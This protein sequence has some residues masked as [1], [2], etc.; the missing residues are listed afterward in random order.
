MGIF[1]GY[2]SK[3]NL[4]HWLVIG[5][6]NNILLPSE[7]KGGGFSVSKVDTF[8]RNIEKCGLIDL[9]SFGTK[10]TCQ[11][12]CRGGRIVHRRLDRGFYN[13]DWCIKFPEATMEHLVKGTK[14]TIRFF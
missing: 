8:A 3:D 5:D 4:I 12:N 2:I 13:Y 11:G 6:F 1:R 7:Q 14:T 10:L 9:G